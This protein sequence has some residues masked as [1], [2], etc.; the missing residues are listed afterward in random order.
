MS[1]VIVAMVVMRCMRVSRAMTV[2]IMPMTMGVI[3]LVA[4]GIACVGA[5]ERHR[6]RNKRADERQENDSLNH[7]A[8]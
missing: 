1:V 4:A 3:H 2:V 7:G 5:K 6:A 8:N